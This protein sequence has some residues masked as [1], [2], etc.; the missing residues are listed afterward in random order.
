MWKKSRSK[1]KPLD[2]QCAE[3]GRRKRT[4]QKGGAGAA[5]EMGR[6]LGPKTVLQGGRREVVLGFGKGDNW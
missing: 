3:S 2:P 4:P 1:R 6:K 5:G